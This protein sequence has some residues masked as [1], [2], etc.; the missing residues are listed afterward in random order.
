MRF[1]PQETGR[2]DWLAV[3]RAEGQTEV[4]ALASGSI[5]RS[6]LARGS[7]KV[8]WGSEGPGRFPALN[9]R[10]CS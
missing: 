1:S 8:T 4:T 2:P 6:V 3:R 10:L 9:D 5:G 7:S